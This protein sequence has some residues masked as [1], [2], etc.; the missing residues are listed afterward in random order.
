MTD[1]LTEQQLVDIEARANA[2][3]PGP[4]EEHP[5]YGPDFYAFLRGPYL[6]GVG[7]L[8]FGDGDGARA[9]REFVLNARHDVPALLAEVRHLQ[10]QRA[11][12]AVR[13]RAG[14]RWEQG[15]AQPLVSQDYVS[16]DELRSIFGIELTAPWDDAT[17]A[18]E[19]C[20]QC[21]RTFD[22]ADTRHA[23]HAQTPYCRSCV[24]RCHESTDAFHVCAICR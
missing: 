17:P 13:L 4:W 3:T 21:R 18:A 8:N 23:Q 7:T 19:T 6:R 16:Q 22:P 20:G 11:A 5:D 15:R 14:Q 2:A 1:R 24:D 10:A 12:L 9:D